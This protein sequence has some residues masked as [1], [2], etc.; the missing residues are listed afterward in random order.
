M[1]HDLDESIR[2]LFERDVLNGSGVDLEFDAPTKEWVGQLN[3][4]TIDIFLYDIREDLTRREV[5][6]EDVRDEDG[7]VVDRRQPPRRFRFAYLVT[8]W[9]KRPEDEHR[10]LSSILAC[11]VRNERLPPEI[12]AG[13]LADSERAIVTQVAMAIDDD[14]MYTNIWSALGGELKPAVNLVC[15]A[16][17]DV[18]RV[19]PFGPPVTEEPRISVARPDTDDTETI[20][21]RGR[22]EDDDR[23]D[24]DTALPDETVRG[25]KE[26]EPGRVYRVHAMPRRER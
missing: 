10:L 11:L 14:R 20:R 16:P 25:G 5:M 17:L 8:A 18:S 9:T 4:P 6:F 13:A 26:D 15:I 24:D 22:D 21:P 19:L 2:N 23:A 3:K 12:L 1:I 7:K